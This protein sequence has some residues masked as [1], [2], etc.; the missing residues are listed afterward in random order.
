MKINMK[1]IVPSQLVQKYYYFGHFI[2]IFHELVLRILSEEEESLLTCHLT[3]K[4]DP[5]FE[6]I[7]TCRCRQVI[8]FVQQFT[9]NEN[10]HSS[11]SN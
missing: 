7:N 6:E 11:Q 2:N 9:S 10:S 1:T 5:E 8:A 3:T 4:F